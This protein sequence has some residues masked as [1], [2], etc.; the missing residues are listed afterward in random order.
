MDDSKGNFK[1]DMSVA[2]PPNFNAI[3]DFMLRALHDGYGARRHEFGI[4]CAVRT[5]PAVDLYTGQLTRRA[6]IVRW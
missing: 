4:Q 1:T 3:A 6:Q 5:P 2:D